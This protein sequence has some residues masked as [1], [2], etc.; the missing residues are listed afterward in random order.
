MFRKLLNSELGRADIDQYKQLEKLPIT[1][2]LDNVRSRHNIGSAFRTSDAFRVN[3]IILCGISST[4]PSAEIHKSAL[5]AEF[6]VDWRYFEK[7]EDA[8]K[9]LKSQGYTIISIEQTENSVSLDKFVSQEQKL[10]PD[11]KY[12]IIFG[13]EVHGIS[14]AAV[15]MSEMAIEIPQ[16]GTKHSLN[17]SVTIGIILYSLSW[18][19]LQTMDSSNLRLQ[20]SKC[21]K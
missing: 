17:V 13:N 18:R 11:T 3:E 14:Q 19:L 6:S 20:I 9:E 8:L 4:P 5:G 7:T 12:A 1:I 16:Y 10:S 21:H 15:D 2:V